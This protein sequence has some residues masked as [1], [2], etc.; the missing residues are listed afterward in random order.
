MESRVFGELSTRAEIA[1][2]SQ[3]LTE[4]VNALASES[5]YV[6]LTLTLA[7]FYAVWLPNIIRDRSL[8][9]ARFTKSPTPAKGADGED[10]D[11][12]QLR[13]R[14]YVWGLSVGLAALFIVHLLALSLGSGAVTSWGRVVAVAAV[15]VTL[16]QLYG[17]A[18]LR[19]GGK[20]VM[21]VEFAEHIIWLRRQTLIWGVVLL[22]PTYIIC[23]L[24]DFNQAQWALQL[25]VAVVFALSAIFIRHTFLLFIGQNFS[26]LHWFLYLCGVEILPVTFAWALMA[27]WCEAGVLFGL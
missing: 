18:V 6:A 11:T 8:S 22:V 14:V 1:L 17:V 10:M 21:Q 15:V 25:S 9:L 20:L 13:A 2:H 12:P 5:W 16:A 26:I 7:V 19:A 3:E 24:V 4:G 27:R 23:C